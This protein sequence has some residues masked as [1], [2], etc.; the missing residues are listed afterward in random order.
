[1]VKNLANNRN[2]LSLPKL[3]EKNLQF[4]LNKGPRHSREDVLVWHDIFNNSISSHR[5]NNYRAARPEDIFNYLKTRSIQIIEIVYFRR[6]GLPDIV[7]ALRRTRNLVIPVT[8][9]LLSKKREKMSQNWW[10]KLWSFTKICP[11]VEVVHSGSG[12]PGKS[13]WTDWQEKISQEQTLTDKEEGTSK[14][15]GDGSSVWY[16]VKL[17]VLFCWFFALC[18]GRFVP[19]GLRSNKLKKSPHHFT[20]NTKE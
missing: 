16:F 2:R 13:N 4:L 18:F 10:E 5:T 3:R 7:E 12:E 6:K 11:G 14:T 15:R 8:R 9:G 1:M 17:L 19:R 20:M